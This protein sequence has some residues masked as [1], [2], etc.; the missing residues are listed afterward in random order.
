MDTRPQGPAPTAL[1]GESEGRLDSWKKIATYLKRD[2]STVQRWERR[3]AMPVHR[4][5]H[6]KLGSVYAFKSELDGWWKSRCGNLSGESAGAGET[7]SATESLREPAGP[8]AT[9]VARLQVARRV[10]ILHTGLTLAVLLAIGAVIWFALQGTSVSPSPLANAQFRLITDFDGI[11]NAAAI[12][13]DGSW[14]AFLADRDG[15][16]DAWVTRV[17]SGDFR[18]L[19]HG[20]VPELVNPSIRTLGFSPDGTLVSIWMRRPDGSKSDDIGILA[21]PTAGG[22]P[23]TYLAEAAEFDWSSDGRR[24]VYHTTAPGDPLFVRDGNAPARR[25]YVASAGVHCHFPVWS[26]DDAFIYFVQGVPPNEWDIWRIRA[27]GGA[28]ERLTSHNA[29]VTHPVLVDR[30]R[31]LYLARDSEGSG[32][33]LHQLDVDRRVVSRISSGVE[34]YTSLAA[35][36]DGSRLVATVANPKASLWRLP[37]GPKTVTE[38]AAVQVAL[39]T[40]NAWSPRLGPDYLLYVS[41]RGGDESV[42]LLAHGESTK[43]WSSRIGHVVGAP[44]IAPGGRQIA[45]TVVENSRTRLL[46]MNADGTGAKVLSEALELRGGLAWTPD[47]ES[48][49]VAANHDG[50]PRLFRIPA[51]GGVPT[52]L[53][54]EYS[55]NPVWSPDGQFLVYEGPDVGTTFPLRAS[56]KD[57]RAHALPN[58]I[59]TRGARVRFAGTAQ[60]LVVLRGDIGHKD[61]WLID[62]ATGTERQLTNLGH[63][64]I[65]RDFDVAAGGGEIVFERVQENADIVLIERDG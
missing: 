38:S 53:V 51:N 55:I 1:L 58:A 62:L 33:W 52:L 50:G 56:A 11:E 29:Q 25:I 57:G 27:S 39:P 26:P 2:V 30:R 16:M 7:A 8:A 9:A 28:P 47:G 34:R 60:S 23:R 59:F 54:G 3:E 43:L 36:A 24:L 14:V 42:W 65:V 15:R 32:P 35:S 64:F 19:T 21:V 10:R 49:V 40:G 5:R 63:D 31:L 46:V 37:I 6:D 22:R 48:I 41:A 44:A 4:H 45:L 61:F 20:S 17:G 12:S 13:R 18:N